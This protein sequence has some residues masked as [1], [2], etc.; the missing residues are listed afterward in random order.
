MNRGNS[1]AAAAGRLTAQYT[2][3]KTAL[4]DRFFKRQQ[5]CSLILLRT[6]LADSEL[7]EISGGIQPLK[8]ENA[9]SEPA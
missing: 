4:S 2:I 6:L 8:I 3:K 1:I 7:S 5:G 9:I